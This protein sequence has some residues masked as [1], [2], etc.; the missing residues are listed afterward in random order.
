MS[1]RSK[2]GL[3]LLYLFLVTALALTVLVPLGIVKELPSHSCRSYS[4]AAMPDR[5][6]FHVDSNKAL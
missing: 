1:I 4:H 6:R 3:S 5:C 2:I